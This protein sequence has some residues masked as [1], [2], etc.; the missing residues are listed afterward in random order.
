M[1]ENT[2]S[3]IKSTNTEHISNRILF[4]RN[5][6]KGKQLEPIIMIDFENCNT[7]YI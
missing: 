5:L 4:I 3:I 2:T 7:E 1:T 6:L